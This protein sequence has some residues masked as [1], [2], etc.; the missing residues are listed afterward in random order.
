M[1]NLDR[2]N[3]LEERT[4]EQAYRGR[5]RN[6]PAF[7]CRFQFIIV[8]SNYYHVPKICRCT[9]QNKKINIQLLKKRQGRNYPAFFIIVTIQ[10]SKSR[11]SVYFPKEQQ[12]LSF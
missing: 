9:P 2:A 7:L 10:F 4:T 11:G 5:V 1:C 3:K 6:G 12:K 8:E